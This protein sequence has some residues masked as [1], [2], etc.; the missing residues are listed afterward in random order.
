MEEKRK[1]IKKF[2]DFVRSNL[3]KNI[4][5]AGRSLKEYIKGITEVV[6]QMRLEDNGKVDAT[7]IQQNI[8]IIEE[9]VKDAMLI[10]NKSISLKINE[11]IPSLIFNDIL[12]VL[13][14][15]FNYHTLEDIFT[16]FVIF[17]FSYTFMI[18]PII[19]FF[20]LRWKF[21]EM[22]LKLLGIWFYLFDCFFFYLNGLLHILA[23]YYVWEYIDGA[24]RL[25]RKSRLYVLI[26][27][28][29]RAFKYYTPAHKMFLLPPPTNV[30]PEGFIGPQ[31]PFIREVAELLLK[32]FI[33]SRLA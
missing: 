16:I 23:Y 13:S 9:N 17:L 1:Y 29:W 33:K 26:D 32:Q 21:G 22:F 2:F 8:E 31:L 11:G 15:I 20:F 28:V 10:I 7:I 4:R 24:W 30:I 14:S 12:F 6:D 5:V 3:H 18:N 27:G 19:A 25:V